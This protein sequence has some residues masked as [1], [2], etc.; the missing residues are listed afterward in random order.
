MKEMNIKILPNYFLNSDGTYNK[1]AAILLGGQIA[2]IC[3]D[4]EGFSHLEKEDIEKTNKRVERTINN[5]HHSVYGHTSISLDIKNLPKMLA[6]VLNN[7]HEYTTSE[8]SLRYT[9][10]INDGVITLEEEIL[11]DKWMAIFTHKIKQQYSG[12]YND[13][14]IKKLAQENARYLITVFMPTEMIYTTSLRQINYIASFMNEYIKNANM[15]DSF[16]SKLS[17]YMEEFITKLNDLNILDERLMKNEKNRKLSIFGE[18]L[19]KKDNYFGDVYSTTYRGSLAQYAQAQRHRTLDYSLEFQDK[20]DYFIPPILDDDNSLMKMWLKDMEIVSEVVPQGEL[21]NINEI[22]K[23][24]DFIL[25]CKERLCTAA[26]LEIMIQ[27]RE[28]LLKYKE[29]LENSNNPLTRDIEKYTHG[30]RCT[31][32]DFTCTEDCKFT[33]GKRLT[34]KI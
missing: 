31:F 22:G 8:K 24:E 19:D 26:Q 32:P 12:I 6:M 21:V 28:T 9:P 13:Y 33:E 7:E 18:N 14:R 23:Y 3:Y 10:V 16:E 5:G 20:K 1:D 11:Y 27:T 29:A 2:G 15:N 17:K 25:K 4:K 30:A 34:R